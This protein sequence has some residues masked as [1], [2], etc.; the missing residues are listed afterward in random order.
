MANVIRMQ[1]RQKVEANTEFSSHSGDVYEET[2]ISQDGQFT[3]RRIFAASPTEANFNTLPV[4]SWLINTV[5][6]V[7]KV[8]TGATTWADITMS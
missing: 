7:I 5:N 4:G 3:H 6:G 1:N 8:K 2:L